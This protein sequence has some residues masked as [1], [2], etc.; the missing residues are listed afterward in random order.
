MD[1]DSERR[2]LGVLDRE[3]AAAQTL[4]ATL[5]AERVALTGESPESVVR[6]AEEKARLFGMIERLEAERCAL[7]DAEKVSLAPIQRGRTRVLAG[8]SASVADRWKALL[9]LIAACRIANDVNGYIINA[10]R[11]QISQLLQVIRAGAP[12]T[13]GPRGKLFAGSLRELAR[14]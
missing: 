14:A 4:A 6:I 12:A 3:I 9:D 11:G 13:Y 1:I 5:D 10:R 2:L 7:C 8:V